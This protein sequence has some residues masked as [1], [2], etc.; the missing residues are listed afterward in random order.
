MKKRVLLI[1]PLFL[2]LL[3]SGVFAQSTTD[4]TVATKD[5]S[6]LGTYL[7]DPEGMTLYIFLKDEPGS[8][9]SVCNDKCAENWPAFTAGDPLALP[10][11]VSGELTQITRDDGTK[12]VAYNGWPLYYFAKDTKAGD[13][14]G[15]DIGE[16]WYVAGPASMPGAT[17]MASPAGSPVASPAA[18][19][20]T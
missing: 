8:G 19:P 1:V 16:V 3:I 5:D 15:Q 13:T 14:N 4:T 12:Q 18:S 17:P 6:K 9:K 2:A 10:E 11:D 7:T 20:T